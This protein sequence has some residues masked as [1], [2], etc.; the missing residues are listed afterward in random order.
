MVSITRKLDSLTFEHGGNTS[1]RQA[2]GSQPCAQSQGMSLQTWPNLSM[3]RCLFQALLKANDGLKFCAKCWLMIAKCASASFN[4]I[5]LWHRDL[6]TKL[7]IEYLVRRRKMPDPISGALEC[8]HQR[9]LA[10]VTR[11]L[12]TLQ[13]SRSLSMRVRKHSLG[14]FKPDIRQRLRASSRRL[15]LGDRAD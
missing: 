10:A 13:E 4:H 5:R 1:I 12:V 2:G 7:C 9:L 6:L 11:A 3:R 14:N 8:V 15:S